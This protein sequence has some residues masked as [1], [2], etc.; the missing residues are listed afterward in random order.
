MSFTFTLK[1]QTWNNE[2]DILVRCIS[3]TDRLYDVSI[4]DT[5]AYEKTSI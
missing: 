3:K 1:E 5:P 4:V 2:G